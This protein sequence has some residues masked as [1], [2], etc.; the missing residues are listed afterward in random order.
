MKRKLRILNKR[1]MFDCGNNYISIIGKEP[2]NVPYLYI[3]DENENV[4]YITDKKVL[5]DLVDAILY[6]F[7]KVK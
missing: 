2:E 3:G 6:S 7:G 5:L 4:G 1:F